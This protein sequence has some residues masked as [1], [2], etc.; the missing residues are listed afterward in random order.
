MILKF[1][2]GAGTVTGSC[3]YIECNKQKILVETGLYQGEN[4]DE[5]NRA[6]FAFRPE[7]IDFIFLTHAHLDHSG[8]LPRLAKEGFK[9]RVIT[10]S[11]T[12]DLLEIM[13]YDA[14][15]IQEDDAEWLT[16]KSLRAGGPPVAPLYTTDDARAAILLFDVKPYDKILHLGTGIKYRFL[17][18]GHIL[19]SASLEL[20]YQDSEREKK[21][22]FSGDI[23]KKGSPIVR[24]PLMPQTADFV[25]M[26]STYGNRLHK[27]QKESI[28]ELV[29]AIKATFKKGG[30]VFIPSFAI[31]RTQ[32]L[33]YIL[34][35]LV[36]EGRIY[37][38][39]VYLDSP[40]AE[41]ATRVYLAHPECFDEEAR[42]LFSTKSGN[43]SIRLHL[44]RQRGIQWR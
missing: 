42:R 24:D 40:L 32:D 29:E 28:G 6:S 44:C 27:P 43:N 17:D 37:K 11:A 39:D 2:G 20:W 9:G 31:G 25:V 8:M 5:I 26:E 34:N 14:A 36:R 13:L 7:E 12:K 1:L 18:A 41:D 35:N 15:N 21:I 3:F 10:T 4:A 16:K 23:G 33:L 22:I 30:N 38:I 19:G